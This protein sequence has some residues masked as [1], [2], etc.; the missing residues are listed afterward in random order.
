MLVGV[1][2]GCAGSIEDASQDIERARPEAKG[3]GANVDMDDLAL[4]AVLNEV[5]GLGREGMKGVSVGHATIIMIMKTDF[6]IVL[7]D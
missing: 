2:Q 3:D 6:N 4:G 5:T 7:N 1:V